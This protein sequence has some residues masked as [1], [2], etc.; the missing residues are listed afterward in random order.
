M[1]CSTSIVIAKETLLEERDENLAYCSPASI[2][3]RS[4]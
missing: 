1:L 3:T 4:L 2:F